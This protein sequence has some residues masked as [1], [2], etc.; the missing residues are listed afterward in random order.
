MANAPR[1]SCWCA[2]RPSSA[3]DPHSPSTQSSGSGSN[4]EHERR[5]GGVRPALDPALRGGGLG[6]GSR[7]DEAEL[8]GDVGYST[9]SSRRSR[10]RVD[11]RGVLA[12]L[13]R[14]RLDS[15]APQQRAPME[16]GE[17]KQSECECTDAPLPR[18]V[19]P[20]ALRVHGGS[21]AYTM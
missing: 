5:E 3:Q 7:L 16:P 10:R 20:R 12:Q 6:L 1:R 17:V 18:R 15:D 8:P 13:V 11:A 19:A 2:R 9:S 14:L 4:N 21:A